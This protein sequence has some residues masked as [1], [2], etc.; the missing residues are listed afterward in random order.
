M[1]IAFGI[2]YD[3]S[4]YCGWQTQDGVPTVQ[5]T[6][7]SALSKVADQFIR[8]YCAGRTDTGVHAKGQVVHIETDA[9]RKDRSWIFGTNANLPRDINV[10]WIKLVD[11]D[12]HGRFSAE[13]RVYRYHILN[14]TSR[15]ALLNNRVVWECR[16]LSLSSMHEAS[17][18]LVGEHDFSA[19]RSLSC[20]AK[21]PV[22][23]IHRLELKQR[24]SIITIEIE[25]NAFLHH[26]VRN[27]AGVLMDIGMGKH[28]PQWAKEVLDSRDRTVGGITAP[29]EGLYLMRVHYPIRFNLPQPDSSIFFY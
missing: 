19:Y 17:A 6:L 5:E 8:V 7:E 24:Q 1:K 23:T 21:N 28:D 12:F 3:G 13:R 27:I 10:Q 22:R 26:M 18:F 20:Q 4:G 14:Q 29:P 2:E 25:A 16:A 9:N 15:S 11:D